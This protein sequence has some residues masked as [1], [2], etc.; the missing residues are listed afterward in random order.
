MM[1]TQIFEQK[2]SYEETQDEQNQEL[3]FN[4][5]QQLLASTVNVLW[6][7]DIYG[8]VMNANYV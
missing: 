8:T 7:A 2:H 4:N 1:T 5:K 6:H 3:T